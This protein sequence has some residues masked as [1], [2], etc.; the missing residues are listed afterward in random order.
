MLGI[1]AMSCAPALLVEG[2]LLCGQENAS[3]TGIASM[4]FMAGWICSNIGM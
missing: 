2:L 4:V 3:I 1:I